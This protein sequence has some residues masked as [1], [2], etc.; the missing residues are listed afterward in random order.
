MKIVHTSYINVPEFH[1]PEAWLDRISFYTG[2][3]EQLAKTYQVE[4]IEKIKYSGELKR[5]GVLYHFLRF[6]GRQLNFPIRLNKFIRKLKPNIV[7]VSGFIL[8][9]P[10]ILLRLQLD[11]K[12]KI[13][14]IN[15]SEKPFKGLKRYLQKWADKFINAYLFPSAEFGKEWVKNGN[16]SSEKKIHEAMHGS[17]FF[18]PGDQSAARTSLSVTGSPI[19]LWVG[20]LNANKDPLTVVKAFI[21]FLRFQPLTKLYMIYQTNELLS[22]INDL[23]EED[24][25]AKQSINL[26]GKVTHQQMQTWFN[27]ADFIISGSHYEGGGIAV[28]EAMSCGCIPIVTNIIS[29]RKLTGP[30]KCGLLYEAGNSDDLLRALLK[31]KDMDKEKERQAVLRQ[32]NEEFS[33]EAIAKKIKKVIA[34]L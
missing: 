25:K 22:P 3:L 27:T 33:F 23:I 15:R 30:G 34:E 5:N 16:I 14:V 11:R 18:S 13:I 32:F 21:Q 1:D 19:F 29:F 2:V 17:S 20:R 7:F 28:C 8:P 24:E 4:S 9:I 6:K 26:I 12:V 31:T 10:I